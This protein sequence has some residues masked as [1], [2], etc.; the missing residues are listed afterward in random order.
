MAYCL[1]WVRERL[2]V[3]A[4]YFFDLLWLSCG[5][6]RIALARVLE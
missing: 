6:D 4:L 5:L 2:I 1:Q 3:K